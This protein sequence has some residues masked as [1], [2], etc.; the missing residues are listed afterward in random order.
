MKRDDGK[1]EGELAGRKGAVEKNA[2][3]S[4]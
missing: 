2:D 4:T 1:E 3:I